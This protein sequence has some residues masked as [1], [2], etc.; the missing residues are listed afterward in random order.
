MTTTKS[1]RPKSKI[2]LRTTTKKSLQAIGSR[3][4]VI[5]IVPPRHVVRPAYLHEEDHDLVTLPLSSPTGPGGAAGFHNVAGSQIAVPQ[6][7]NIYMGNFWGDQNFLEGFSKAIV[8]NGYLDPLHDLNYGTGSGTYQGFV[9]GNA[10]QAGATFLDSD[11]QATLQAM[12]DQGQIQGNE[13]SLFMLILPDGVTSVIDADG[14]QSC[15]QFCGYHEAF[16]YNG[17][18]IAYGVLPSSL[19]QGCGGQI[20]DFTAV[21]AHE[22]AEACTDKVP[23]QGWVADDGEENG[24]LEAWV[25]FGWGPP[26]DPQRYTIQGYYTNEQGDTVG[27]WRS[28]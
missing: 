27:A 14:S 8:E 15:Q 17:I 9:K 16:A 21:Y 11:A 4:G 18:Q 20:G 26:D 10:L 19:C 6:V 2:S 22:L 28:S 3:R 5:Q 25:L 1:V 13:N 23:G 24:D 12:L 7:T